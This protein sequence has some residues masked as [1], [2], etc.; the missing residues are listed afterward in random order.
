[1][2]LLVFNEYIVLGGA[3]MWIRTQDRKDLV[4]VVRVNIANDLFGKKV[5]ISGDFNGQ[6]A[7]GRLVLGQYESLEEALSILDEIQ[8]ALALNEKSI[9]EMR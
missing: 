9:Y 8:S 1:M 4:E 5:T 2:W 7:G 3:L 6:Y